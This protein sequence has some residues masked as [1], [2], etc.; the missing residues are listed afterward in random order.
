MER[1]NNMKFS[2]EEIRQS[3]LNITQL[4]AKKKL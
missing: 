3:V 4:K 1:E 2:K